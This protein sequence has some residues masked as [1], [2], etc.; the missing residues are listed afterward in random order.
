MRTITSLLAE[1]HYRHE[2]NG[3]L[4]HNH[5]NDSKHS[6]ILSL[7]EQ[8]ITVPATEYFHQVLPNHYMHFSLS[9]W[10]DTRS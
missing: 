8:H 1:K 7:T 10:F 5:T 6:Y 4:R 3:M 2:R 9:G